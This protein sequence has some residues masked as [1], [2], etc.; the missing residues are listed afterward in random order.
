MDDKAEAYNLILRTAELLHAYGTP[1]HRLERVMESV[2][3]SVDVRASFFASPTSIMVSF[4][5]QPQHATSLVRV[6]PGNVD[7]GKL[8]EFDEVLERLADG[9]IGA[10]EALTEL[11]QLASTGSRWPSAL[12][13]C[14]FGWTS[15][16]AAV[17]FRG[18]IAEAGLSAC[19]GIAIVVL[20]L[21]L[22]RKP[23]TVGLFE[24]MAAFL[25]AALAIIGAQLLPGVDHRLVALASIIVLLPGLTLTTAFTELATHHLTSGTSRLAG[26]AVVLLMLLL[27]VAMAWRLGEVLGFNAQSPLV[28]FPLPP[29]ATYGAVLLAPFSFAILFE[30]RAREFPV[31]WITCIV[32]F[33]ATILGK[34]VLGSD[35]AGGAG[36]LAV[37]LISNLYAR[38]KDRPAIIPLTPGILILVPGSL[39]YRSLTAFLESDTTLGI[40][41]AFQTG[42]VAI[43]LV[44]GLLLSNVIIPPRRI[45]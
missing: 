21:L 17:L 6:E 4:R 25:S 12:R 32:G 29:I 33:L 22:P 7:L 3:Q 39:G 11:N 9:K 45:L 30:A 10:T 38:W 41:M 26:A 43:S 16:T 28:R 35:L 44:G 15:G 18:G 42:L 23:A 8:A 1:A 20:S 19:I 2:A 14:A 13:A 40:A 31:I 36:A 34:E 27:G 5:D 24:P 37:G